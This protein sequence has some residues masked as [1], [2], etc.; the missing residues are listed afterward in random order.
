M[1]KAFGWAVSLL[2][3]N[4]WVLLVVKGKPDKQIKNESR[5][6]LAMNRKKV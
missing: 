4:H 1:H 5:P 6:P 2:L 3:D